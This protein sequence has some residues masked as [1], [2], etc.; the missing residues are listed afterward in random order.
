[1]FEAASIREIH[2]EITTRCGVRCSQ[3]ARNMNGGRTNPN[4]PLTEL[5]EHDLRKILIPSFVSQ[6]NKMTICGNYG[7]ATSGKDTYQ[8]IRYFKRCNE[9]LDIQLHSHGSARSS[10]WWGELGKLGM[11]CHFGIDG[12]NDT[13]HIYRRGTNWSKIIQNCSSYLYV[14]G[15]TRFGTTSLLPTTSTRSTKQSD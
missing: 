4:L 13:N 9:I 1:M 14:L 2:L 6:L 8:I 15:V 5:S 3:C 10:T 12:L 7:D 11:T